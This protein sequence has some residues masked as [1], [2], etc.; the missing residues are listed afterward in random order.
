MRACIDIFII[1]IRR[2]VAQHHCSYLFASV[3]PNDK[4][5]MMQNILKSTSQTLD[6]LLSTASIHSFFLAIDP[7][8]TNDEGFLGGTVTG[9]EFWRGL[10]G[11][12]SVGAKAFRTH[13]LRVLSAT[14]SPTSSA[15]SLPAL[16]R[17]P[18]GTIKAE[19]YSSVRNSLRH[20]STIDIL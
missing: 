1:Q 19:V 18:A 8:D 13:C 2:Y 20:V 12:G 4:R 17:T 11:G 10:R 7:Y 15:V 6:D 16:S 5:S 9:R 14:S 3:E